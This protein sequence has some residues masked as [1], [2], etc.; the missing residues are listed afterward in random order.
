MSNDKTKFS[1]EFDVLYSRENNPWSRGTAPHKQQTALPEALWA[2]KSFREYWKRQRANSTQLARGLWISLQDGQILLLPS[3][4][5]LCSL[6]DRSMN[7]TRGADAR[8]TTLSGKPA[9]RE[10][11]RLE[12]PK[13]H[14]IG[15]WM[16]VSFMESEGEAVRK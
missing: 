2:R 15:V 3:P 9:D 13:N 6:H 16:P 10:D 4:G 11:G 5:S 14:L 1:N 12:S 8:K 7:R